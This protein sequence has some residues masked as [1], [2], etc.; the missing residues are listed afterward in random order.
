MPTKKVTENTT[1]KE[2]RQVGRPPS[3]EGG[4][5]VPSDP[6]L[7]AEII[8]GARRFGTTIGNFTSRVLGTLAGKMDEAYLFSLDQEIN[9]S[10]QRKK[11]A[12]A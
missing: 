12:A 11:R 1:L 6:L 3:N 10:K 2:V 4:I 9:G 8:R 7:R 5:P